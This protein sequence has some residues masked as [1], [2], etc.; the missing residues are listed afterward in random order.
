MQYEVFL[1]TNGNV[2]ITSCLF[3]LNYDPSI[4]V[5]ESFWPFSDSNLILTFFHLVLTFLNINGGF[6]QLLLKANIFMSRWH[7][8][9]S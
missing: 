9:K 7:Y 3:F 8:R 4:Y 5:L 2:L 1:V 6:E